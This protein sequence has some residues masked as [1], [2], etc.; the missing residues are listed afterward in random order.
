AL[1]IWKSNCMFVYQ[2][3]PPIEG[4]HEGCVHDA[5]KSFNVYGYGMCC[6]AASRIES[7]GRYMGM[8]AR[9]WGING[10]SV[11]ELMWDNEWHLLDASLLNYFTKDDGKIASVEE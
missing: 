6:C 8:Q 10:H 9:G 4:L 11:P 3:N 5:I 7:L 1:A 2:D